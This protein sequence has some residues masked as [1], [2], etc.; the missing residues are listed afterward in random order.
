MKK[1]QGERAYGRAYG[2]QVSL[3]RQCLLRFSQTRAQA[4]F[5]QAVD[6][7]A[8]DHDQSESNDALRFFDEDGGGQK[9]GIFEETKTAFDTAL[10]FVDPHNLLFGKRCCV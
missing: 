9:Q 10:F 7:Q 6:E 8:E 2:R 5:G 1:C 3:V 4:M